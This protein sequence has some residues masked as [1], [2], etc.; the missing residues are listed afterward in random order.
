MITDAIIN[1]IYAIVYLI[2][3]PLRLLNDVVMPVKFTQAMTTVNN[4][5]A[6]LNVLLPID[7]II[8]LLTISITIEVAYLSYKLVMWIIRR[9]P[10]QS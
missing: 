8:T 10:T 2:S 3:S 6:G 5:L 1:A 7:T 9:F 4:Y